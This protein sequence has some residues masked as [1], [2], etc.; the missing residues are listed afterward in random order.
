MDSSRA[1]VGYFIFAFILIGLIYSFI[2]F[3]DATKRFFKKPI[4]RFSIVVFFSYFVLTFLLDGLSAFFAPI[5]H[6]GRDDTIAVVLVSVC[7]GI[8]YLAIMRLIRE[9]QKK[10]FDL[11]LGILSFVFP[12]V[13][14]I[15]CIVNRSK[16]E[17]N[18]PASN[19]YLLLSIMPFLLFALISGVLR[20]IRLL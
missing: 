11:V 4:G 14:I 6:L 15:L 17:T 20:F 8:S 12:V 5:A 19:A 18:L 2:R 16:K 7:A 10:N 9:A 13:G 3:R 1:S